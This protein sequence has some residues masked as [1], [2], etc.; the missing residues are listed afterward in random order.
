MLGLE[1][2]AGLGEVIQ[3]VAGTVVGPGALSSGAKGFTVGAGGIEE[4]GVLSSAAGCGRR[5][6]E[7][8]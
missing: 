3:V 4:G 7:R 6:L 5:W 1:Q 8:L 2:F